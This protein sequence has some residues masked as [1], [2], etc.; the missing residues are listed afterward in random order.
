LPVQAMLTALT[1]GQSMLSVSKTSNPSGGDV[2]PGRTI[3]YTVVV[4]NNGTQA[5]ANAH[6]TGV[7]TN[8]T[9]VPG[10]A[11]VNGAAV[12]GA[13]ITSVGISARS[14]VSS[15][16]LRDR[17]GIAIVDAS[18]TTVHLQIA[19][20]LHRPERERLRGHVRVESPTMNQC[21]AKCRFALKLR[22]VQPSPA[23]SARRLVEVCGDI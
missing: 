1:V 2:S 22:T 23:M 17:S 9:L 7:L 10:S 20:R 3:V 11:I 16:V 15:R 13:V 21:S 12:P 19:P 4:K 6:I 5:E 8:A 18:R 14:T